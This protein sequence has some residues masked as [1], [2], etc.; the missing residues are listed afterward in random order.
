MPQLAD[1]TLTAEPARVQEAV[2]TTPAE[3]TAHV[4]SEL[5]KAR[6][7]R[8]P[9]VTRSP[10]LIKLLLLDFSR[11]ICSPARREFTKAIAS[12]FFPFSIKGKKDGAAIVART[13][14]ITKTMTNSIS[15][16]PFHFIL[17][18]KIIIEHFKL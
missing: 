4:H 12:L 8:L 1:H 10:Q 16:N 7:K 18:F 11:Y 14:T 5:V 9:H 2:N 6:P 3:F 17:N 13:P 15:V